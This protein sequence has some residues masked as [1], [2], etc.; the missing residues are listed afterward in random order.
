MAFTPRDDEILKTL[1]LKVRVLSLSQ[2]A[3]AWWTPTPGG[4]ASARRRLAALV[5]ARLLLSLP[6][7]AR[8][9][10]PIEAPFVC[11][12]PGR[13]A[14]D[15]GALAWKL[16]S[17]WTRPPR[18]TTVYFASKRGANQYGG[19]LRG[20]IKR[21]FQVT[22]DLGVAQVYLNLLRANPDAAAQ[23]VGEDMLRYSHPKD[24]IPDA[25]LLSARGESPR[26]VVE[27]GGSYDVDRLKKFHRHCAARALPY[28]IY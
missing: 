16:Q 24:K 2:I 27:F 18:R 7:Q 12:R 8:P 25:V 10:P 17:R 21:E 6:I 1:A 4:Q 22:H 13:S 15:F 19:R 28:E 14:P 3:A 20:E 11:W 26:L 9:L 5:N 23:W